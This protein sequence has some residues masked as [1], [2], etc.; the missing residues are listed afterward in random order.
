MSIYTPPS[1]SQEEYSKM[2]LL[3]FSNEFPKDDLQDL[4]RHLHNHSKDRQHPLL[5]RFIEEATLALRDEVRQ[6]SM[7]LK[8]LMPAFETVLNL[9]DY[10][11]L[12]KGPLCGSIEGVLLCVLEIGTLIGY[13]E[14]HPDRFDLHSS[15]TYLSGLGMGILAA[16]SVALSSTLA[17]IP[18]TGAEVV[19]IAF[20]LGVLVDDISQNLE[21]R[22]VSGSPDTWASVVPGAR[23]EDVQA[24]LDEIHA[25]EKTPVP[26]KI[27]MSAW[28]QS[29]VTISGPP[30]RIKRIL[31]LSEFFRRHKVVSLP[32]F[33]GLCHAKHIYSLKH[34]KEIVGTS[35]IEALD[36]RCS[37]TIPIFQT[38]TGQQFIASTAKDLF[39]NIV[40]ELL[41]QPILWDNVIQAVVDQ[42]YSTSAT[43]CEIQVFRNSVPINELRATVIS[44]LQGFEVSTEEIIPWV[45]NSKKQQDPRGPKQSKLAIIGMS[46]RMPGGATDTEK[47]WELLEQGLDVSRK[48]P[49]DRFDIDTHYDPTGKRMNTT[50]T[51]YGCF[52]DEPGL[53]DAP[54]FNMSPREAQQTDPM[55][56]LAIVTAY[57]ALERAGY[58]ANRTASTNLHRIGTFYGQTSDD[59]REVNAGQ[60]VGTYFIPGG[61][62]AFG[63]GRINYFFKFAGPSFSCDTACS[64]SLA[65]IQAS[66]MA[67]CTSLWNGD[68]DM[69]VAGGMNILTN[70]DG[71]AGLG[72]GHFLSKT[73]GA[74][75]TWD[76]NADGYCRAD[77]IGS[78]VI[79][80]LEDAEADND[81]ILGVILAAGTNHSAEAISITHPHA[82]AQAYLYRQVM[83][84]AG[85]DPLDV[86]FV[87]MHGTGTQAG[88]SVEITSVTDVFAPI[89]KRRNA[90]QPLHIGA[91]KSNVG[92]GESVA[93]VT[94]LLKVLLM[95]QK[96]L[97]P[98]HVGIKNSLNPMFPKDLDK[99]NLHIPYQAVPWLRE[100][101]KT[102]YAVVNNFSA[103]GG[104]TTICLEEPPL[105]TTD[106]VDP[107]A[108]HVV[109]VSAKSK[110]SLKG[111]LERLIT[112]LEA[113]PDTSL[114]NLSYT[115][116]A[117]R[118]H[119]NHRASVAATDINQVKKKLTS[120]LEAVDGH[121]PI[122]LTNP[123]QVTFAF[124]GQGASFKSMDLELFHSCPYFRSQI[125][126]LD[127]L[128]QGQGFPSFIPA[129]DGSFPKDHAHS[130]VVTQL[131]LV[132]V[133]I[134]LAKYWMSLGVK[135]NAVIGH[136]LGE[137]AAFHVAG[138]LSASDALWLV[139]RRAQLLEEKCQVGSH[140]MLAVRAP[141]ADIEKC[142]EG[143]AYEIACINGPKETV[144][145]GSQAEIE[146]VSKLLQSDGYRCTTLDVTFAFHSSQTDAIL[147]DFEEAAESGALFRA[148]NMPI[149]SPLL[150]KVIFDAKT[151]NAKYMRRATREAVNFLAALETAQSFSTIDEETAWVEIGPH[152]VCMGFVNATLSSVN[153]SVA[154]LRR[155]EDN[156]V[157]LSQSLSALHGA[158][159]AIDWNEYQRP[160]ESGLRLLDLPT[161]AWNDKNYWL[162]Y[163]GDWILTK[164]NTFYDEEKGLKALQ[165]VPAVQSSLKTSTVQHVLE[166]SFC[167]PAGHVVM[168]S[169]MMQPD[170]LSAAHG[171]KMNGCGV[172]TSSIH[173]D[174]AFT[175][176]E[177]LHKNLVKSNKPAEMNMA[178]LVVLKGLV[179]QKNTKK[180]QYIRVTI[181]TT[182]INS[183][184]ADL[185]WQN[186]LND[187]TVDEPFASAN[188]YYGDS[189][190]WLKTW[191]PHAHLVQGRI[192]ALERLAEEGTANRFSHNMAYLL[193]ANNL[194]DYAEKYRGM[195]SVVLNGLEAFADVKLTMEKSGNWTIPP[196]F[197]DSVAHLAGFVM[198]VSDAID[199]KSDYCVTPGWSSLRFAKPLVAGA[200]YR[201]YVKM[202]PTEEDPSVYLGDVYIMQDGVIMGMCGGIKFRRYPRI[203]L[204]R[205]FTAPEE[206]GAVSHT[207]ASA[208]PAVLPAAP[209]SPASAPQAVPNPQAIAQPATSAPPAPV[210]APPVP[211]SSSNP[212]SASSAGEDNSVSA[213][214][215][216]LIANEASLEL[217]DL[218]D[219]ASFAN[220]GIDSLMSLV[221]S[222]KFREELGVT[223]TGSLFLEYPTI[224]DLRSW[225]M[226]YYN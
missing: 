124:T 43:N 67:A 102:R 76:V 66:T 147:D 192:E 6:I 110:V 152:P 128:A 59:Y 207:T 30:S 131:A 27:F 44:K 93:G 19:R 221:I 5:A 20:R 91:V 75:K 106:F 61:C 119:H 204:S 199:T 40:E 41:T 160:F 180:P 62:R 135:P 185:T 78:V 218:S 94:A 169:D 170:F 85:V 178:N 73:P 80:R 90:K 51:P 136:S 168:Q 18:S 32:V 24:E 49:A 100:E 182:D 153:V 13:Y 177:Y 143:N 70:C 92:H 210:S 54:F 57:E 89:T 194:V 114:A 42:A 81:N 126:H 115:T 140:K 123:P 213:K 14:T 181:S 33:G 31:R 148:P 127:A 156:W 50:N 175:L 145:S 97:I 48:V 183:G 63:P 212:A 98:P 134:A 142:L 37:P 26:S 171:H 200:K 219:D 60:E 172:V 96:G 83:N 222:E 25:R 58:V 2:K 34:V 38:S 95:Y 71:F 157:T 154:S 36:A 186:V 47:F 125:L 108:A 56:R 28:G 104:N 146:N 151:I 8:A 120:Y 162:Q 16:A 109:N 22:D 217:S 88:D 211:A 150:G 72:N 208:G 193:F 11:D 139:G 173:A 165:A 53:F 39:E 111:N 223:V 174:I 64:S 107:R 189:S 202:I 195:Q 9:V 132:S 23:P 4:Y 206:A 196:Y 198:N 21:P 55:Q 116:T 69:V 164:G 99:R 79:K 10:P 1:D 122:S 209:V 15:P 129:I 191:I 12:R 205:F 149:I 226:E 163:N 68:T 45:L 137:Y 220:L 121:K 144:L 46:C 7:S 105:R 117:R 86:S 197:I 166:E 118:Y 3:Y 138:V 184:V 35:S 155:G 103:A 190:E 158:G 112:Y 130:P 159:I 203:L 113:N 161:Y 215:L 216:V 179:A 29:S 201:S 214:A 82:G 167:G 52:I 101:G 225:L 133:E 65:T 187:G 224:G 77:G 141:L 87:E 74:C 84:S 176:G 17:D 188:I